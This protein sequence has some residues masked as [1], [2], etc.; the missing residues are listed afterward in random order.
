MGL[1]NM[2]FGDNTQIKKVMMTGP[3][4]ITRGKSGIFTVTIDVDNPMSTF[5]GRIDVDLTGAEKN[6]T[7]YST[8]GFPTASG[9][10][11]VQKVRVSVGDQELASELE[12]TASATLSSRAEPVLADPVIVKI[13]APATPEEPKIICHDV[14][15]PAQRG[16][17]ARIAYEL[18]GHSSQ[19][20]FEV[21][22]RDDGTANGCSVSNGYINSL[23][24]T[25]GEVDIIKATSA[26]ASTT[27]MVT[28]VD[29]NGGNSNSSAQQ[30]QRAQFV[31]PATTTQTGGEEGLRFKNQFLNQLDTAGEFVRLSIQLLSSQLSIPQR[32]GATVRQN[33]IKVIAEK[34]LEDYISAIKSVLDVPSTP[35][36]LEDIVSEEALYFFGLG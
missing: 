8:Q 12:L 13:V 34:E 4:E 36:K 25:I 22:S 1:L 35:K 28:Y 5:L 14:T 24:G 3:K 30:A 21:L 19:V 10:R 11:V 29:N 32:V 33:Q 16:N 31:A 23:G 20:I 7:N 15:L 26:V 2:L 17:K 27:F 6:E 9:R 18:K